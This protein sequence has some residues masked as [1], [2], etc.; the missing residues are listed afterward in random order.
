MLVNLFYR[1][2]NLIRASKIAFTE[3]Q[4]LVMSR[5]EFFHQKMRQVT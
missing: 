5:G 3:M 2:S 1:G 4:I